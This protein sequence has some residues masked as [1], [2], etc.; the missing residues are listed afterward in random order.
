MKNIHNFNKQIH[1]KHSGNP[2]INPQEISWYY[3]FLIS[4]A[5]LLPIYLLIFNLLPYVNFFACALEIGL[6]NVK[7]LCHCS[8]H[9]SFFLFVMTLLFRADENHIFV[10]KQS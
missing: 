4:T 5:Q 9:R 8:N 7:P 3:L 1:K 6:L 2:L 10:S